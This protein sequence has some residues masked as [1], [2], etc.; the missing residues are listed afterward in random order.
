MP[1]I[2]IKFL[3][4]YNAFIA[5]ILSLIGFTS[6]GD[7]PVEYG[8]PH[9]KFIVNGKVTSSE[10]HAP[11]KNIQV[12]MQGDTTL[13]DENGNFTVLDDSGFP[14]NQTYAIRFQDV[15]NELNGSYEDRDTIVEFVDPEFSGGDSHWD[16]GETSQKFDV[17][18]SPKK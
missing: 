9:A 12:T 5:G 8:T 11:I 13:T 6:C 15:D 4:S 2:R 10:T 3:K 17:D 16:S 7:S 14:T 18:L 1:I